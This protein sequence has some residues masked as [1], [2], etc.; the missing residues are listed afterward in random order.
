[1]KIFTCRYDSPVGPLVLGGYDGRL[2]ICDWGVIEPRPLVSRRLTIR[3]GA[4]IVPGHCGITYE[5]ARQLDEYFDGSRREFG[6]PLLFIGTDFQRSVWRALQA[7]PYGS[8]VSYS[9]LAVSVGR[10]RSVRAVAAAVGANALS[11]FVPC[12]RVIGADGSLTGYAGGIEA[13]KSLL[14]LERGR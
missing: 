2:C 13:K 6:V 8:T 10:S 4:D 11:V 12:H 14:L 5:A 7:V 3:L 1:M 9:A